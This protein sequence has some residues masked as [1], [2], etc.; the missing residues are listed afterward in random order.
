MTARLLK[1]TSVPP[2]EAPLWVREKWVGVSLPL[3]QRSP[4]ARS[5]R[6][7][8][9]ISRP[10]SR[11]GQLFEL[12]FRKTTRE[13]GFAVESLTAITVLAQISPEAAD[14]WRTNIPALLQPRQYFVF[15]EGVGHVLPEDAP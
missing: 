12:L 6:T 2:G 9:V 3:A 15:Q 14:W 11:L 13:S 4:H 5:F 7:F 8:G 1:I 10:K